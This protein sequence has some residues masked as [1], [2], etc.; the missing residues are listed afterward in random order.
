MNAGLKDARSQIELQKRASV[1][2]SLLKQQVEQAH[3]FMGKVY[4]EVLFTQQEMLKMQQTLH[5]SGDAVLG[6]TLA[7]L[8][9]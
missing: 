4:N 9:A 7:A 6:A 1:D 2:A 5:S 8:E 3:D